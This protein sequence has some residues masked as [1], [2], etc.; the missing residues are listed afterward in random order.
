MRKKEEIQLC[1]A[2]LRGLAHRLE[3]FR[4]LLSPDEAART[5]RFATEE[6][7]TRC[8]LR[9][10]L[11]RHLLGRVTGR[12][13]ASLAFAYGPMGKPSLP[14][15]PAFNLADCKDH[16]L[17]AIAPCATVELGVDVER[18]RRLPDAAGIAERFFAPEE[19]DAFAALPDA[20]RD[21]AFLNGWTRKE[22][23]IK[24]TGQGLSTP[25][26]RFAVELTPGRP[27]R[28]LSLDGALEAGDATDWSLF[29]LRPAPGLV[30]ALAVH[31]DG[32]RPVFRPLDETFSA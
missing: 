17:I 32:W 24:A 28:L 21:E 15:G 23:F 26:D 8:A 6:L 30:G 16:V 5:A 11:L 27:A 25:L 4:A 14:G 22:A 31:G 3:A 2:D 10:G 9:R 29:D 18:L 20:L 7:R 13:P 1:Y 19:R 12:D